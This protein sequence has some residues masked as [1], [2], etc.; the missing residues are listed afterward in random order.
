ML[1]YGEKIKTNKA[2]IL[3]EQANHYEQLYIPEVIAKEVDLV[4]QNDII[5]AETL[6]LSIESLCNQQAL[7][8]PYNNKL[9]DRKSTRLNSSH[10][11]I[12]YA[13]CCLKAKRGQRRT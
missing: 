6:A 5:D 9:R 2:V 11:A 1:V 7:L 3:N 13:V 10:V 8:I 12:S 4:I